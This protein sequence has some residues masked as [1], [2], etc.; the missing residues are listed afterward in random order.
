[1]KKWYLII[2]II[3]FIAL[4][5]ATAQAATAYYYYSEPGDYIGAGQSK[6]LVHGVD[7]VITADRNF[8][9]G[10]SL[11]YDGG[12]EWWYLD[13]AAPTF[14]S[15]VD[16]YVGSYENAQRF[17]FNSPTKPGLDVSG[18]GRGCNTLIGR[19][20]VLEVEYNVDEQVM[21]FAANFEQH[22]EGMEPALFG[23]IRFNSD[24]PISVIPIPGAFWLFASGLI[25]F[26]AIRKRLRKN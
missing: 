18:C 6:M 21:I 2:G 23:Q 5:T 10:V 19:F 26:A 8:D 20:D 9:L 1:M 11:Y 15:K 17:P 3:L 22:C 7:G 16:L 12:Q 4:L 14:P 13:F 24:I 25:G